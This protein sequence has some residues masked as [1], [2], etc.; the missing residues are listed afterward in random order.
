MRPVLL[1][2]LL[3]A[4]TPNEEDTPKAGTTR[5]ALPGGVSTWEG[6]VDVGGR[7]FLATFALTLDGGD[8]T[9]DV[10]FRDDPAAPAGFGEGTFAVRGTHAP[11]S[12]LLALAPYTWTAEPAVPSELLGFIGSY[13]AEAD[14]L[15]GTIVDYATGDD[16][17]LMGGP[18]TATRTSG[19]GAPVEPGDGANGLA[20]GAHTLAGTLTCT[21]P[22]REVAADL[23][24]DG[25]G[26]VEGTL[27]IGDTAITS[28][29]GTFA[30]TG[31]HNPTTGS[32]TLVPG[33]W[34]EYAR[35]VLTFFIHGRYD[36][37]TGAYEGD[38][39][40]NLDECP[41]D[42]WAAVID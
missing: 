36:A 10:T 3:A 18:A 19:D 5:N 14:A 27:T 41:R 30:F 15:T 16:N 39:L 33:K 42:R 2:T 6:T 22:E 28:P 26:G 37:A 38:Q 13:D 24:Y 25:A 17:T 31:V 40:S 34:T 1:L 8:V 35:S 4:C 29:L 11:T 23:T 20:D 9:G 32:L 12:G 7:T 21:G